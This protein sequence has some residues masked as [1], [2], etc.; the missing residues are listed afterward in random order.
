MYRRTPRCAY[1]RCFEHGEDSD[2]NDDDNDNDD[3]ARH[4][5][6]ESSTHSHSA[7]NEEAFWLAVKL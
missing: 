1:A 4:E 7:R 5:F 2:A 3:F 6:V